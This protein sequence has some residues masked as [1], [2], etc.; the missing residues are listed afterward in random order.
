[1]YFLYF[2]PNAGKFDQKLLDDRGLGYLTADK[3]TQRGYT[4]A[5][6]GDC[7]GIIFADKRIEGKDLYYRPEEQVWAKSLA[8]T[9]DE[10]TGEFINKFWVG[11]HTANPP[12]EKAL[13]RESQINGYEIELLEGQKYRIPLARCFPS[14][15]QLPQT[16]IMTETGVLDYKLLPKY[17]EFSKQAE[18]LWCDF[19]RQIGWMEGPQEMSREQEWMLA[20]GALGLNYHIG[21]DEINLLNLFSTINFEKVLFAIVDEPTIR[22]VMKAGIEKKKREIT[23]SRAE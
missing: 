5:G 17:V 22:A 13:A 2:V 15:T 23:K 19:A 4:S 18:L 12:T 10:K 9:K 7:A 3:M 16:M 6:P 11:Y 21:C 8:G 1:M 14:G 20:R